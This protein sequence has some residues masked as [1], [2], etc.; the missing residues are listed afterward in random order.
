MKLESYLWGT[1]QSGQGDGRTFVNP[2]TGEELGRVDASGLDAAAA[3][4][5]ARDVGGPALRALGFAER[6]ALLKAVAGVLAEN[7]DRYGE[8]ARLNSG[9]TASDAAIDI[10]G[11]IATLKVY[12]RLGASLGDAR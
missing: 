9:N 4:D 3:M 10:D 12:A 6:G 5:Y 7:R 2:V 8:I 1:W 11:A